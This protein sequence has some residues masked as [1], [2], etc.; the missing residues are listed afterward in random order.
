LDGQSAPTAEAALSSLV[1]DGA[2]KMLIDMEHL[3]YISSASLR[4]LLIVAKQLK[5]QA[6]KVYLQREPN[7]DGGV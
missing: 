2:S 1:S 3:S 7:G 4:V 6:G 5:K